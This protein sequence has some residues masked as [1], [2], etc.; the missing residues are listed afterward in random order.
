[1]GFQEKNTWLFAGIAVVGYGVYVAIV[2][3]QLIARPFDEI[4]WVWPML[5]T[6]LGAIAAGI[7][8]G[9]VLGIASHRTDR[10]ASD[11][12]DKQIEHFG[13]RVGN[14]FLVIGALGALILS[15]L[16]VPHFWI[17]NLLYLGFVLSAILG[18]MARLGAYRRG[19]PQW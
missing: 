8:G 6:I 13:E 7:L 18:S 2:L 15:W 12:R 11:V 16:A 19:L 14:A 1:M 10:A 5:G 17:G 3:P 4:E 9:I